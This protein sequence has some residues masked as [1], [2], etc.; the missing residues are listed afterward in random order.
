[1]EWN[2]SEQIQLFI[3]VKAISGVMDIAPDVRALLTEDIAFIRSWCGCDGFTLQ[4]I[5]EHDAKI[6]AD[7][8]NDIIAVRAVISCIMKLDTDNKLRASF[9]QMTVK[10]FPI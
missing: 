6:A 10:Y 2:T 7:N 9:C 1:M 8:H 4:K 5:Y 3:R